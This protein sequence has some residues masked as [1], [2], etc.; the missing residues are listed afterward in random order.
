VTTA[1]DQLIAEGYL[2]ADERRATRVAGGLVA[3]PFALSDNHPGPDTWRG[4]AVNPWLPVEPVTPDLPSPRVPLDL[5]P[6]SFSLAALDERAW[7]R[8]LVAAWR[9]LAGEADGSAVSYF[10][11]FGDPVLRASLAAHLAVHRGVRVRADSLAITAGASAALAAIARTWLGPGRTCVIEDPSGE[12]LRRALAGTG[13]TLVPVPVDDGGLD[14]SSLPARA[15]VAFVTPSWQYPSGGR[16]LLSR[17]LALLAWARRAS[18]LIVEDDCEG[19]LRHAGAPVPSLQGLAED[20]R[21]I[22]VNT[23]SKVLFPGLR[24]GY[25]VVPDRF[26]GPLLAAIEAGARGPGALE[27]RALGRLVA[28]GAYVRHLRRVRA[29]LASRRRAFE[30]ALLRFGGRSSGIAVRGGGTGGHLVVDLPPGAQA[31]DVARELLRAGIRVEPLGS[32]RLLPDEA[33][34]SL[35][36]YLTSVDEPGLAE[37]AQRLALIVRRFRR[38]RAGTLPRMPG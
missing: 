3:P 35:V 2:E 38:R 28:S 4:P 12:Q 20:G 14:V 13:A 7:G 23:F 36:V 27:Q 25:V 29:M 30:A 10:G 6:E 18:C 32:N 15:D 17:R 24:T 11:G 31:T 37:A 26:R 8:R 19:E 21:V 33:D 5:G 1:F 16:M 9:E 22:Y 34:R